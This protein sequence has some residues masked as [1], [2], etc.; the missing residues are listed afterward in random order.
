[1]PY[2]ADFESPTGTDPLSQAL[3][4]APDLVNSPGLAVGAAQSSDPIAAAQ[5]LAQTQAVVAANGAAQQH[6][7][8]HGNFVEGAL[9]WFG[10]A[11]GIKQT[12]DFAYKP[13][14]EVQR[15]Y[16]FL[17]SV[18]THHDIGT[19]LL[20][21][22]GVAGG[23][24]LG[25]LLGPEG[26]ALG[27]DLAASVERHTLGQAGQVFHSDFLNSE[28]DN[29]KVSF[30]RDLANG[31]SNVP[32]LR[33][34]H[35]TD[36]GWGQLVSGAGDIAFDFA[37]DPLMVAGKLNTARKLGTVGE[38][39]RSRLLQTAFR[40]N[41]T[42]LMPLA[43]R[44]D[45]ATGFLKVIAPG[46]QVNNAQDVLNA[47]RTGTGVKSA[48]ADMAN[49]TVAELTIKHPQ[50]A[51]VTHPAGAD[52]VAGGK[53][54]VSAKGTVGVKTLANELAGA[55]TGEEI[56]DRFV[57]L[58]N[59]VEWEQRL[60][61]MTLP[62]RTITR[63]GLGLV[64]DKIKDIGGNTVRK[65]DGEYQ[66]G[67]D[68]VPITLAELAKR[69]ASA[70]PN[71]LS[72]IADV[73]LRKGAKI[74][75][76]RII[77]SFTGYLPA[78]W[79]TKTGQ[80]AGRIVDVT[81]PG[82]PVDFYR[83]MRYSMGNRLALNRTNQ[84]MASLN[85]GDIGRAKQV[86]GESMVQT[87]LAAGLPGDHAMI[88]HYVD[89]TREIVGGAEKPSMMGYGRETGESASMAPAMRSNPHGGLDSVTSHQALWS[90]QA[91][92][93]FAVP[94][95]NELKNAVRAVNNWR[96]V[97]VFG[98]TDDFLAKR[99]TNSFFK[100]LALLNMGFGFRVALAEAIPASM[101]YG[102]M[103]MLRGAVASAAA[104]QQYRLDRGLTRKL[105]PLGPDEAD[106]IL[107]ASSKLVGGVNRLINDKETRDLAIALT[108]AND[109]HLAK[110]LVSTG[111]HDAM[112]PDAPQDRIATVMHQASQ[113]R[114]VSS[115]ILFRAKSGEWKAYDTND[116]SFNERWL[117]NL[118]KRS[119]NPSSQLIADHLA[120]TASAG[121]T[122]S[123]SLIED[124]R[125]GEADRIRMA[126]DGD[127]AAHPGYNAESRV[128]TRYFNQD[129]EEFAYD[130]VDDMENLLTGRD[131]VFHH[132]L[133][134]KIADGVKPTREDLHD[135][136]LDQKPSA[137]AGEDYTP[138]IGANPMQ[139]LISQGFV[140]FI[141]PIINHLSRQ[142]M[143]F[144]AVQ[145]EMR[146]LM[147]LV[148]DDKMTFDH[149]LQMAQTRAITAVIPQIHMPAIRSQF[150]EVARNFAPFYFAQEQAMKRVFHLLAVNPA[151]ARG[152]Q[153][154][155][156]G[157]NEPGFIHSDSQGNR[158]VIMPGVGELGNY[159]LNAAAHIGLPVQG[160]MPLAFNG[161]L[162]S[163][164][165]VLPHLGVPSAGPLVA[166]PLNAL[167][168]FMPELKI[169][170]VSVDLDAGAKQALG[171]RGFGQA[172][173]DEL[174]PNAFLRNVVRGISADDQDK[175]FANAYMTSL[176]AAA[177]HGH[178]PD[179]NDPD[180]VH[181]YQDFLDHVKNNARGAFV[182]KGIL[183]L[184]SPLTPEPVLADMGKGKGAGTLTDEF[185]KILGQS[186]DYATAMHQFTAQYGQNAQFY[187]VAKSDS[188]NGA[189]IP[190][191]NEALAWAKNNYDAINKNP[192]LA[193][194]IPQS[195]NQNGDVQLIHQEML[196]L[197]LRQVNTPR[198]FLDKLYVSQGNSKWFDAHAD[199]K[200]LE[201]QY[202]GNTSALATLS[203]N[204]ANEQAL[205]RQANPV[206][207]NDFFSPD[208]EVTAA[209]DYLNLSDAL[210]SG[211]APAG[212]QTSLVANLFTEF[213]DYRAQRTSTLPG[214]NGGH[215]RTLLDNA[216]EDRLTTLRD[217]DPRLKSVIDSIFLPLVQAGNNAGALQ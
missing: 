26:M 209:K 177:Y 94:D 72:G 141:D 103:N 22:L 71:D 3:G 33:T 58:F 217:A 169:G 113:E 172:L 1:M 186:K 213:N 156:H 148:N 116:E 195:D 66:L 176:A 47:Y 65:L 200:K 60:Q 185:Y 30:G 38:V 179:P 10:N 48:F 29:Y 92:V 82:A 89:M 155:N 147:R 88:K 205:M 99:F 162:S 57:D 45:A 167:A 20:A 35:N 142:P 215:S 138:Y 34:L 124:V 183:S 188:T 100:P 93:N 15:D 197:G 161:S 27:G 67:E 56:R 193:F 115:Q 76:A 131:G 19:A 157:L 137:V 121:G 24:A 119:Q 203:S 62:S 175:M 214:R 187:T 77:R 5:T 150:A 81:Q 146:P 136:T 43:K 158:Y 125:K 109:G 83:V 32:G 74:G 12:L 170:G 13:L 118:Q 144:Q 39:G 160:G 69:G 122:M 107:A 126:R 36:S 17:H 70:D 117:L 2:L 198:D 145:H 199:Y 212:A 143:Y 159:A 42:D 111:H 25:T 49:K 128:M 108:I 14:Q 152:F 6:Q 120:R 191:T 149:A 16:K 31:L 133:A 18:W 164:D 112:L 78:S 97:R 171:Q 129:P 44:V 178:L 208:R 190:T 87:M 9:S 174:I 184:F 91:S 98:K 101:R 134:Q 86:W 127:P 61:G 210:H 135:L 11:P 130:R 79:D 151:A 132:D 90:D 166:I 37:A 40:R 168:H 189:N 50:L 84:L 180:Y 51:Y 104:K 153:L 196:N 80:L 105:T 123:R 41:A 28:N 96:A 165:T 95:F 23:V 207:A 85:T 7:A 194:L 54:I 102:A 202:A 55:K 68:G 75:P 154:I 64:S 63:R 114:G 110:G 181:K 163:L 206:W 201:V 192:A 204:W 52:V 4:A 173:R 139:R 73:A 216:W 140:K 59:D 211:G 46:L 106:H 53:G 21:T 182:L 8:H